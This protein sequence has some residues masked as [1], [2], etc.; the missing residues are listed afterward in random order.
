MKTYAIVQGPFD[1]DNG[2]TYEAGQRWDFESLTPRMRHYLNSGQMIEVTD[3]PRANAK[4]PA[5][6]VMFEELQGMK[7][8]DAVEYLESIDDQDR[9][10]LLESEQRKSVLK[11]FGKGDE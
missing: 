4:R 2:E 7:I 10:A 9:N 1:G 3:T 11:H 6:Q 5:L 8:P